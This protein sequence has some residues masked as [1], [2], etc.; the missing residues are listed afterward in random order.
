MEGMTLK[1]AKLHYHAVSHDASKQARF[2]AAT[3]EK[4][5]K[6]RIEELQQSMQAELDGKQTRCRPG[7]MVMRRKKAPDR[8]KAKL[9]DHLKSTVDEEALRISLALD[10]GLTMRQCWTTRLWSR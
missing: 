1:A 10:W 4:R 7:V 3:E 6:H 8:K 2:E 5:E 9:G